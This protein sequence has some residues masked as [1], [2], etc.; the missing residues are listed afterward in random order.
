M[1]GCMAG[2]HRVTQSQ[3]AA[4][5]AHRSVARRATHPWMPMRA[6]RTDGPGWRT[7]RPTDR[8]THAPTNHRPTNAD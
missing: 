4:A 5:R 3:T 7:G 8:R 2:G 6:G 1:R